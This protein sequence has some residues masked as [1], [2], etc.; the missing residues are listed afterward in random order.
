VALEGAVLVVDGIF[1][2]RDELAGY[3]DF[4]V[5]LRAPFEVAYARMATRDG[6]PADPGA[7]ENRRYLLGQEL[8]FAECEPEARA[9]VVVDNADHEASYVVE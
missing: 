7:P 8:Y 3:W 9:T 1:V 6:C 4:S 2:H 5:F